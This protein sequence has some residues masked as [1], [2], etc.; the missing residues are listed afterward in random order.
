MSDPLWIKRDPQRIERMLG[1]LREIWTANPD[2]RL[3][4]LIVNATCIT[5]PSPLYSLS[6]DEMELRLAHL[7]NQWTNRPGS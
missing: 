1:Q 2:W 3:G 7:K 4:Q 5:E 6:D